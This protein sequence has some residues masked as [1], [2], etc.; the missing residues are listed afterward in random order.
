MRWIGLFGILCVS[1]PAFAADT[2]ERFAIPRQAN[3]FVHVYQPAGDHFFGPDTTSLKEGEWYDEWV[4]NDHA[5]AKT[6]DG[7][8]HIIGITHPLV[9][10]DPLKDGI[11]EGEYASF[12][13][14]SS[15]KDFASSLKKHDYKDLPKIL[16]PKDRPGE[17]L[18]NHAPFIVKI[19]GLYHMVYG[20]SP[21]R[22][23]VS[24]DLSIW[25]L[26]GELFAQEGGARDPS[27]LLHDGT[28]YIS[29][30]SERSVV[31]RTSEDLLNWGDPKT[32]FTADSFDPES[33]SVVFYGGT[34]Y[35]FV[36]SWDGIWDQKGIQGAYQHKTY[37]YQ[38]DNLL[39]FGVGGKKQITTLRSHA[40]EILQGEDGQWYLSSVEWPNRGVSIDKLYWDKSN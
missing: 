6:N 24:N 37:V 7:R 39:D 9:M 20:P 1:A 30:C 18:A 3:E 11:H 34:F 16:P 15:A 31:V 35:L 32:V 40:P 33:P 23:A 8:W 38:S 2:T 17:P 14:V 29:Y 4:P 10:T 27:V 12:H 28:Y 21:I 13:A 5:F 19:D 25:E 26:K 36:C 22:L